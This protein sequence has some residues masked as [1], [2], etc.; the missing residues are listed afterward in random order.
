MQPVGRS[1][2][3]FTKNNLS[4]FISHYGEPSVILSDTETITELTTTDITSTK[5]V[6]K[7]K[8]RIKLP[9]RHSI[10]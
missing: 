3:R 10:Q 7:T 6:Q 8:N 9:L 5:V 1:G 2:F 4:M